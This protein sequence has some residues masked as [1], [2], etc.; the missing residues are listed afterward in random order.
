MEYS[1]ILF[2]CC[3]LLMELNFQE[4]FISWLGFLLINN[5]R[6]ANAQLMRPMAKLSY[7][8]TK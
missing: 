1:S 5:W 2:R 7:L 8:K 3:Q 4:K 6:V